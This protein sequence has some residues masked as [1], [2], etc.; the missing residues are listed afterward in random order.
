MGFALAGSNPAV[1]GFFACFESQI[2]TSILLLKLYLSGFLFFKND[3]LILNSSLKSFEKNISKINVLFPQSF[4]DRDLNFV[5]IQLLKQ[6]TKKQMSYR[7]SK[8][9]I[10]HKMVL[11]NILLS[12]GN[13]TFTTYIVHS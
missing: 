1:C 11:L 2:L 12:H 13:F 3:I 10:M 4:V 7:N 5:L 6:E 9:K 8:I